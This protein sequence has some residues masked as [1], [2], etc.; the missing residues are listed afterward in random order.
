MNA[1]LAPGPSQFERLLAE[2]REAHALGR[3]EVAYHALTAAMH[4]AD[5]DGDVA[6]LQMAGREAVAQLA[7]IDRYQPGHRLSTASAARHE[8]PGVYVMLYRQSAMHVGLHDARLRA[9][10]RRR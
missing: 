1:P 5:D 3:Y 4:A 2:S 10:D 8:H 6:A 7:H 9:G